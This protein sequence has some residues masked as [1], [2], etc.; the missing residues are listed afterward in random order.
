MKSRAQANATPLTWRARLVEAPTVHDCQLVDFQGYAPLLGPTTAAA[1]TDTASSANAR[2]G[3]P[4]AAAPVTAANGR[5]P[6]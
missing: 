6:P 5:I 3:N 1:V 4:Q 2:T